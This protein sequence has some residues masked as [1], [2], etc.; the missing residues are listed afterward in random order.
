MCK[1]NSFFFSFHGLLEFAVVCIQF[2][3][4]C[5][6]WLNVP[7]GES[8]QMSCRSNKPVTHKIFTVHEIHVVSQIS[9]TVVMGQVFM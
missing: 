2:A 4:L 8:S 3:C 9:N 6:W 5:V 1:Q 7:V